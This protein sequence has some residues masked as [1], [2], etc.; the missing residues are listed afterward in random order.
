MPPLVIHHDRAKHEL[1]GCP[2]PAETAIADTVENLR[3]RGEL[4]E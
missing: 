2:R 3:E 1:G 4:P